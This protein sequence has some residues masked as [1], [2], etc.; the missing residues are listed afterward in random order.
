MDSKSVRPLNKVFLWNTEIHTQK[1]AKKKTLKLVYCD[2]D[3]KI[4]YMELNFLKCPIE[5]D[6]IFLPLVQA[7]TTLY[8]YHNRMARNNPYRYEYESFFVNDTGYVI[9]PPVYPYITYKE[10]SEGNIFNKVY[11]YIFLFSLCFILSLFIFIIVKI[12]KNHHN[13]IIR[14]IHQT[15]QSLR[16]T[17]LHSTRN[18]RR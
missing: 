7:S 8:K 17:H 12:F 1:K 2:F 10:I 13:R 9:N 16:T 18:S 4:G 6:K 3:V 15:L 14:P 11:I 5:P